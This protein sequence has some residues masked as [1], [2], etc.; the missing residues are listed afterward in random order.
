[1]G[2]ITSAETWKQLGPLVKTL[3]VSD[4]G[5]FPDAAIEAL[6]DA[7]PAYGSEACPLTAPPCDSVIE[8][9]LSR[10]EFC[11]EQIQAIGARLTHLL[12]APE[13]WSAA[14][15]ARLG[16]LA[17]AVSPA[18]I[19][20]LPKQ[21]LDVLVSTAC[22][23]KEHLECIAKRTVALIR[24]EGGPAMLQA[25]G[26]AE[27]RR[28]G[29]AVAGLNAPLLQNLSSSAL[30]GVTDLLGQQGGRWEGAQLKVI[31][32]KLAV[33]FGPARGWSQGQVQQLG[34]VVAGVP[35]SELVAMSA[36]ALA[37]VT[38]EGGEALCAQRKLH[39]LS[40]DQLRSVGASVVCPDEVWQAAAHARPGE[41][42]GADVVF[43]SVWC[44]GAGGLFL[45]G[46]EQRCGCLAF[47]QPEGRRQQRGADCGDCR[48][49]C[50]CD[51][52]GGAVCL[53]GTARVLGEVGPC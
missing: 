7:L 27:L 46:A 28:L 53:P 50:F 39:V 30:A 16:P 29:Q 20:Q 33:E 3:S 48:S 41:E 15:W 52:F 6:R 8:L 11:K 22:M 40:P 49:C 13:A 14:V 19:T 2:T 25:W 12:G 4:L 31:A 23:P 38:P 10:L 32:D 44:V 1:V 9:P 45:G 37:G 36:S 21:A 47:C 35:D 18:D 42:V 17:R 34:P 24:N 5:S 26:S 43:G 51:S